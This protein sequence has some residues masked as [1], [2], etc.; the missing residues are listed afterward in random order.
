MSTCTI[1]GIVG[2]LSE[3][4]A[5]RIVKGSVGFVVTEVAYAP[6]NGTCGRPYTFEGFVGATAQFPS[7]ADPATPVNV[8]GGLESADRGLVR[9]DLPP[10]GTALLLAGDPV[11]FQQIF[12]DDSGVT[13]LRFDDSL[14]VVESLF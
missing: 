3:L 8:V 11:S 9:F 10:S 7:A 2:R 1:K 13:I 5:P 4:S 12:E 6:S 14:T